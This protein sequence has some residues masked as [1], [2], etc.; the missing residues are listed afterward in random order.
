[1][2]INMNF[3]VI[4]CNACDFNHEQ[5]AVIDEAGEDCKVN[6]KRDEISASLSQTPRLCD[7]GKTLRAFV[8]LQS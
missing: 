2:K 1:M 3:V 6:D 8:F 5:L 7:C 4:R